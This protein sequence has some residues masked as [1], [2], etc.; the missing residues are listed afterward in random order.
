MFLGSVDRSLLL[1]TTVIAIIALLATWMLTRRVVGPVEELSIATRDLAHGHLE[2]RVYMRGSNE[3]AELGRSFN[4]MSAELEKQETL[5]RNLVNDVVHELR[6][7][8]A[9]L[10]CRADSIMDGISSNPRTELAGADEEIEH[11]A[12]LV[13]D[14]HELAL[15]EARE[16]KFN[17]S[18]TPLG[19]IVASAMRAAGLDADPRV[20]VNLDETL[21]V[22]GDAV[23]LR[24]IVLNILT[25]AVRYT[26]VQ[27][28]ITIKTYRH[29]GETVVEVNNTGS[30]LTSDELAHVFDRFYRADPS[31]QRATGGIGL[32]LAI[33]KNLAEAQGGH[34]WARSDGSSVTFA[35]AIPV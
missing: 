30:N 12:R 5:R 8:L 15:A 29:I 28:T 33:V 4:D 34:V 9:A 6:T 14:L 2:R 16:L 10:R 11:L 25:N 3:I 13:E 32:G 31:R 17:I 18:E 35:F 7:P 24:Q 20:R 21:V 26:P 1:A 22:R 19:P 23:R 27:G